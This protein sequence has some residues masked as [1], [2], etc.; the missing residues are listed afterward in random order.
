MFW[1]DLCYWSHS[2]P[3]L[4]TL[5]CFDGEGFSAEW[6][7]SVLLGFLHLVPWLWT[8]PLTGFMG[9][10]LSCMTLCLFLIKTFFPLCTVCCGFLLSFMISQSFSTRIDV[11]VWL[12]KHPHGFKIS[13]VC[14]S[15]A[16]TVVC[17]RKIVEVHETYRRSV[18]M[19]FGFYDANHRC[20]RRAFTRERPYCRALSDLK[21]RRN[22]H[23]Y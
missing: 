6:S 19:C 9:D 7:S 13:C 1:G 15:P 3:G 17:R 5:L 2:L 14:Y 12:K 23:I 10:L 20:W 22:N 21:A 18:E 16:A 8:F 4:A 11:R